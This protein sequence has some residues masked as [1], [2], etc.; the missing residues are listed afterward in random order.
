MQFR[1]SLSGQQTVCRAPGEALLPAV[2]AAYDRLPLLAGGSSLGFYMKDALRITPD[3]RSAGRTV[4][5]VRNSLLLL[6]VTA[7]AAAQVAMPAVQAHTHPAPL[8]VVGFMGGHIRA[9]NMIHQEAVIAEDLQRR[10]PGEV[11]VRTFA[12]RDGGPALAAVLEFLDT[13]HDGTLSDVEKRAARVV[14]YGHSWGASETIHLA[15]TLNGMG[16]PVLL[17]IQVDSVQ[18]KGENDHAIPSN[19]HEAMNFYQTEGMLSGRTAI[20]AADPQKTVILGNQQLSYKTAPVNCDKFP[21][22]ARTF[23]KQHIEIENDPHVWNRVEAM[24]QQEVDGV[25]ATL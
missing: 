11:R 18:K 4:R 17:T 3:G 9:D 2:R 23:M 24:I 20:L 14:I 25:S 5:L 1:K 19:V 6:T 13:D 15:G 7:I 12:N 10:N 21:W 8:L 16:V 22:F